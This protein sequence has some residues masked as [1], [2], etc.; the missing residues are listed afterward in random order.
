[1]LD[2]FRLPADT[3]CMDQHH[4]D[5]FQHVAAIESAINKDINAEN[6]HINLMVH[7]FEALLF[8]DPTAF[9]GIMSESEIGNI[10]EIRASFDSVRK[11]N[12][13]L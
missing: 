4:A 11:F 12:A 10:A 8:S 13:R 9:E 7:E 2:Y 6:C 1:M 3:P 5:L